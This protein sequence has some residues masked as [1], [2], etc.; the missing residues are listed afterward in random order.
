MFAAR[1]RNLLSYYLKSRLVEDYDMLIELLV[2]NRLKGS[3]PQGLFNYILT[4]E[5]GWY[6]ASKVASLADVYTNNRA[7]VV[8]QKA[9][10]GK[11]AKIATALT[12]AGTTVGQNYRGAHGG[13]FQAGR[14]GF[15]HHHHLS[16]RR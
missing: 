11:T 16:P 14:G 8:G 2:S 13:Q 9:P 12:S 5:D 3:L 15:G 4:Q 1:L 10:E 7:P 6:I